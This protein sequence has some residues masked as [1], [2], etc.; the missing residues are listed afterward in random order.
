MHPACLPLSCS[1]RM[2]LGTCCCARACVAA[3]WFS[4]RCPPPLPERR[5]RGQLPVRLL[6]S[7]VFASPDVAGSSRESP[8]TSSRIVT[9]FSRRLRPVTA[10]SLDVV[11]GR[12]CHPA[13]AVAQDAARLP[14]VCMGFSSDLPSSP[15]PPHSRTPAASD[16]SRSSESPPRTSAT[17]CPRRSRFRCG[18]ARSTPLSSE[19]QPHRSC[20]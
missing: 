14:N 10:R 17:G 7:L 8:V 3:S 2:V 11:I 15:P 18:S 4:P 6:R 12:G 19:L 5:S 13:A 1:S 20:R 9:V 16:W